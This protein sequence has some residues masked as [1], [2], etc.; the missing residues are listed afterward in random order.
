MTPGIGVET[1]TDLLS[2]HELCRAASVSYRQLDY[3]DRTGL[4]LA[5]IAAQG[6]GTRRCYHVTEVGVARL[7]SR[8]LRPIGSG[9][10][11]SDLLRVLNQARNGERS[12]VPYFRGVWLDLDVLCAP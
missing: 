10:D 3:W 6:S 11:R 5:T 1:S 12:V 8:L 7:L 9:P 2:S 4:L